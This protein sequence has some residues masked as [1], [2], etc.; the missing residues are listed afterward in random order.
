MGAEMQSIAASIAMSSFIDFLPPRRDWEVDPL[1]FATIVTNAP[2]FRGPSGH[3]PALLS[4]PR[5]ENNW[6]LASGKGTGF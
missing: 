3:F 1:G 6:T 4:F 2:C 5:A